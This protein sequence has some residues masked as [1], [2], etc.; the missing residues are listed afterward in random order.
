MSKKGP[1]SYGPESTAEE[2]TAGIDL[3]GQNWLVTGCNSG[4]G[5]ETARV[6]ALRG[7]H[8]IGAA[9]TEKK[10]ALAMASLGATALACELS[11]PESVRAA[12]NEVARGPRLHGIVANA[13]IMALQE[14]EQVHGIERQFFV[15]HVGHFILITG[16]VDRLEKKGRVVVLSSGAHR[17]AKEKGLELD[18]ASGEHDYQ[19]WRMYGRSKLANIQFARFLAKRLDGGRTAN[20]LHPGVIDT[21][22][23]RHIPDREAMYAR[24]NNL[25]SIPQGAATQCYVATH[26]S[27]A[28]KT[29]RYFSDTKMTA[30]VPVAL[31]DAEGAELWEFTERLVARL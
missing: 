24:M 31:D 16:L 17:M 18:N 11:D 25:K 6:L 2:V 10:A 28:G 4:L 23:G 21:E 29:G 22:L 1:S 27:L 12:V 30:P 3:T 15:N 19:P 20:A 5:L 26:P 13:G 7:A 9:R 14:L 8:V